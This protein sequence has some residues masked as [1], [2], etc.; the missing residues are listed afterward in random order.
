M[1]TSFIITLLRWLAGT[2]VAAVVALIIW[3]LGFEKLPSS[4]APYVASI[5]LSLALLILGFFISP[6]LK[7]LK[8]YLYPKKGKKRKAQKIKW[9]IW[10]AMLIVTAST[11]SG[12][13]LT[14]CVY[15]FFPSLS[16]DALESFMRIMAPFGF[17]IIA[18]LVF[19]FKIDER[20]N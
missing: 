2:G 5:G 15:T 1:K 14:E 17:A 16:G 8:E 3:Q 6:E 13:T 11:V 19:A 18:M 10:E 4:A 12:Y 20:R 9:S 7:K